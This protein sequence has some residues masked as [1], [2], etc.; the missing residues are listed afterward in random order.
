MDQRS[1][2]ICTYFDSIAGQKL[3]VK[4]A[5]HYPQG[6][7]SDARSTLHERLRLRDAAEGQ[8]C[9]AGGYAHTPSL[10][11]AS[12]VTYFIDALEFLSDHQHVSCGRLNIGIHKDRTV[13]WHPRHHGGGYQLAVWGSA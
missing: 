9:L 3:K 5:A 12:L 13:S 10:V 4:I 8:G 1:R 6:C 11:Y 7:A 2:S